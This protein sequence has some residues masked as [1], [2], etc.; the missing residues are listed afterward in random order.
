MPYQKRKPVVSYPNF[1]EMIKGVDNFTSSRGNRYLIEEI[2]GDTLHFRR[3]DAG[4]S[5][6]DIDLKKLFLA[7]KELD[8]FYTKDFLTYVPRRHSPGRG[9]LLHLG[10]IY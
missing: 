4:G 3:L 8:S 5:R 6:W 9:L 1:R 2:E 7:Y 10:L